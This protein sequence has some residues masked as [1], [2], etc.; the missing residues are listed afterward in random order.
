[1][2]GGTIVKRE[3]GKASRSREGTQHGASGRRGIIPEKEHQ[4]Q[5]TCRGT[6]VASVARV[7]HA[8]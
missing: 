6:W 4:A 2:G 3:A 1:M 5:S 8:R 7:E